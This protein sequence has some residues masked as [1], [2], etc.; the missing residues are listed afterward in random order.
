MGLINVI[1]Y[2]SIVPQHK[3][4]ALIIGLI[5]SRNTANICF[6]Q[7]TFSTNFSVEYSFH[8]MRHV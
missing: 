4:I 2:A 7:T 8:S 6:V 3:L 1:W 5:N